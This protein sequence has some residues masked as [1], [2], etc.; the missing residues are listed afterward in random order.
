MTPAPAAEA[1]QTQ[2]EDDG[3]EPGE[4][5]GSVRRGRTDH[6]A[7]PTPNG[8]GGLVP[9]TAGASGS[10]RPTQQPTVR[11]GGAV[12]NDG[13]SPTQDAGAGSQPA[14]VTGRD[15]KKYAATRPHKPAISRRFIAPGNGRFPGSEAATDHIFQGAPTA[16]PIITGNPPAEPEIPGD[17]CIRCARLHRM[18]KRVECLGIV[19]IPAPVRVFSYRLAR[20]WSWVRFPQR[21]LG[22][23]SVTARLHKPSNTARCW[24]AAKWVTAR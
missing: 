23:V 16:I 8:D 14:R 9:A 4:G 11:A 6:R 2:T 18:R 24:G 7:A 13:R 20:E 3:N 12:G 21:P 15:G 17:F 19:V 1:R 5:A 22:I 10:D